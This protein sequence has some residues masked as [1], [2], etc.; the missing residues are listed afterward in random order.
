MINSRKTEQEQNRKAY[1]NGL[2]D[3]TPEQI[4]EEEQLY[5]E[6]KRLELNDRRYA[7]EREELLKTFAGV[8]SGLPGLPANW[9]IAANVAMDKKR[10]KRLDGEI[11]LDS[12]IASTSGMSLF[13]Q[14]RRDVGKS[15]ATGMCHSLP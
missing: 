4:E 14:K 11:S 9:D 8:E 5:V 12:P 3:R 2:F 15:S 7:K 13:S 10:R 1:L 6:I